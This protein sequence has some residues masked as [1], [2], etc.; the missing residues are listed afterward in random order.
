MNTRN[1]N[2]ILRKIFE[3]YEFG[4]PLILIYSQPFPLNL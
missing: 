1:V 3:G 2:L 4:D